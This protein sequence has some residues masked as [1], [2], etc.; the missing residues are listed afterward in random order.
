MKT[1]GRTNNELLA[2][3]QFRANSPFILTSIA[4]DFD[5][6]MMMVDYIAAD[7]LQSATQTES[8]LKLSFNS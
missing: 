3:M 7:E 5:H 6:Y 8:V 2:E 1:L 4:N